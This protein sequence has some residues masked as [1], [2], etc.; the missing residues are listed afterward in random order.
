MTAD[1]AN[2]PPHPWDNEIILLNAC[3]SEF[4][5]VTVEL[6]E[7]RLLLTQSTQEVETLNQRK[8][9]AG[10][11]VRDMEERLEQYSRKDIRDAYLESSEAEMR[12]FML[13]EQRDQWQAKVRTHERY[14]SFLTQ[15]LQALPYLGSPQR[16]AETRSSNLLPSPVLPNAEHPPS[17]SS[18]SVELAPTVLLPRGA[19]VPELSGLPELPSELDLPMTSSL[20]FAQQET[21][22][23]TIMPN[24]N[25]KDV[26]VAM[27]AQH[28][29]LPG[30]GMLTPQMQEQSLLA[31]VIAAQEN[32]RSRVAQRLHD[33][34]AQALANIVLEAEVCAK[35]LVTNPGR[36]TGELEQLKQMVTTTLQETRKFIFELHPMTLADLGLS[37]TLKRYG[38]EVG[39]RYKVQ[40][41]VTVP[42]VEPFLPMGK[43][44]AIFRVAQEA[45][46]NTIEHSQATLIRIRMD[47]LPGRLVLVVEDTGTGFD[48]ES[49]QRAVQSGEGWGML[50]MR[51]RAE[52]LGGWLR[53]ESAKDRGTRVELSIPV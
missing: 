23:L 13:S 45:V 9:L 31:R 21:E 44:V 20:P 11:R 36:V 15:V 24:A 7:L 34:P 53:I 26:P 33:G 43:R 37:T 46:A 27:G 25:I 51:E 29:V 6:D 5:R 49:A 16:V 32:V 52:V 47:L 1:S 48:V 19:N 12:A 17:P 41:Q 22:M 4:D 40:V 42:Q 14:H 30:T 18:S 35:L 38:Q 28:L 3:R 39:A 50:G 2:L 8:V 10:A